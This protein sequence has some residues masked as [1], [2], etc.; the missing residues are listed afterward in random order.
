MKMLLLFPLCSLIW[1]QVEVGS[2]NTLDIMTWN[3]EWFPKHDYTADY[4]DSLIRPSN[5][6]IIALQEITSTPAFNQLIDIMNDSDSLNQWIG[7]RAANG[8]YM[9]LAYIINTSS[10]TIINTP[11]SILNEYAHYFAYRNPY[12]VKVS[13]MNN[14]FII[15]NN[16]YKCCGDGNLEIDYW[17]EEYRRQQA[18]ILLKNYID[19]NFSNSNVIVIGDMNDELNDAFEDNI[20]LSFIQD[21]T[22]YKFVDKD[23]A[24][25]PSSNWSYPSWP[26]HLDHIFITNELFDVFERNGSSVETICLDEYFDEYFQYISDHR[27][28][29]LALVFDP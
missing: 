20:F 5:L 12:V 7:F 21:N 19:V 6:D 8:D 24:L 23:I 17:D 27:P 10:V 14:E 25:G 13:Y 1:C 4:V 16:H 9:E 18:S 2:E 28:V 11:Y 29:G 3:L 22:N 26:S 15:I